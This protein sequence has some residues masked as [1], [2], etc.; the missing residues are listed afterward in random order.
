MK[1]TMISFPL[2]YDKQDKL[3]RGSVIALDY[4]QQGQI[5]NLRIRVFI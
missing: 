4:K 5:H 2:N 3:Q 1:K